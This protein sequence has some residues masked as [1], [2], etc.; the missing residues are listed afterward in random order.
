MAESKC[1]L[2][3]FQLS[4]LYDEPVNDESYVRRRLERSALPWNGQKLKDAPRRFRRGDRR[5]ARR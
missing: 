4:R 5:D 1:F 2:T 3:E